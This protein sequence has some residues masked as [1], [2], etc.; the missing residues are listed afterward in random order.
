MMTWLEGY[1]AGIEAE[2]A[3]VRLEDAKQ[4]N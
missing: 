1:E 3:R 2:R 4:G